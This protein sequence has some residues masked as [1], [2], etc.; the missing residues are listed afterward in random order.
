MCHLCPE[1][2]TIQAE[3]KLTSASSQIHSVSKE[4][5]IETA[6]AAGRYDFDAEIQLPLELK[7][8]TNVHQSGGSSGNR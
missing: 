6:V 3:G 1:L 5:L 8:Q 4:A 7:D 2:Q